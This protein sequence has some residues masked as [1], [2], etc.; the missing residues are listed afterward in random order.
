MDEAERA[1]DGGLMSKA[2]GGTIDTK[3]DEEIR[4]QMI[5]SGQNLDRIPN[6]R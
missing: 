3:S 5:S 4:K 6:L 1:Y 2:F